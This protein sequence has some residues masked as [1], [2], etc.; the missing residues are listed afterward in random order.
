MYICSKHGLLEHE[1]CH[2]CAV[3]VKCDCSDVETVKMKDLPFSYGDDHYKSVT[4]F[5]QCCQTC[6]D[7][8]HISLAP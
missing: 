7:V 1:W 2:Q 4:V 6:G 3:I 8:K 5:N